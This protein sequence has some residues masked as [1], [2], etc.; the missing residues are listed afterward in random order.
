MTANDSRQDDL[1]PLFEAVSM[2]SVQLQQA[3]RVGDDHLV[4]LLDRELDPLISA[5]VNY[6]AAD[7]R[8]IQLQLRFV[9]NLIREDADD[10]SCVLRHAATLSVLL[11]R[12]FGSEAMAGGDVPAVAPRPL[13][14]D[15]DDLLNESILNNLPDRVAVVTLDYRYLYANPAHANFLGRTPL[16]LVGRRIFDFLD[17]AD[18]A[19]AI[20]RNLD[21]CFAGEQV[22]HTYLRRDEGRRGLLRYRLTPLRTPRDEVVGAVMMLTDGVGAAGEIAA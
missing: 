5:V 18:G 11:D 8:E 10:R 6:R 14:A 21:R 9:G 7:M 19:G 1:L 22:D 4:R 15:G 12:Y 16:E 3:I 17:D 13:E 2:K 20:E